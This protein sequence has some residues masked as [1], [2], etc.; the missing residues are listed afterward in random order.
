M[1]LQLE[2]VTPAQRVLTATCDEVRLPGAGGGFGVRPGHTALVSALVPGE[3]TYLTGGVA[4]RYAVGEGFGEI[5]GDRVRVLVEEAI[6]S[7]DLDAAAVLKDLDERQ[8]ALAALPPGHP[9]YDDARALVER[10]A[11]KALVAGRK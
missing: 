7:D 3:L 2:I 11:A 6:K 10:A 5:E 1:A 4:I 8:K 9:N